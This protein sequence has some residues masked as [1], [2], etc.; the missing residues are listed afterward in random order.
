M[1][2]VKYIYPMHLHLPVEFNPA[3]IY[4]FKVNDV[5]LV[6]LSLTLNVFH[7]FF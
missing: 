4:L 3:N 5:V 7:T 6:F 1:D 2:I